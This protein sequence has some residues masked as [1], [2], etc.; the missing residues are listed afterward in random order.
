MVKER[1]QMA[2]QK[3][4][5][6]EQKD[7]QRILELSKLGESPHAIARQSHLSHWAIVLILSLYS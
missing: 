4:K 3:M 5:P 7:I 1:E 6:L 2:I